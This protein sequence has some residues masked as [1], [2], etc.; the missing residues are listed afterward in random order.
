MNSIFQQAQKFAENLVFNNEDVSSV[1]ITIKRT[2]QKAI[3]V[4]VTGDV[5]EN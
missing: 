3:T 4:E 5:E 2:N 1:N